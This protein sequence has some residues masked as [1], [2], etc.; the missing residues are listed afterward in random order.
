MPGN[1]LSKNAAALVAAATLMTGLAACGDDGP[2]DDAKAEQTAPNGDVF[3]EVDVSFATEMI[4]H[5]AQA[6]AMVDLTRGREL[7]P[8][9]QKLTENIQAAQ[10]PEIEQMVDWL[11]AWDKPVPETMRDHANAEGHG[12]RG[13]MTDEEM[14]ELETA[15]GEEFETTWLEMMVEHHEGAIEMAEAEQA[16]GVYKPAKKLAESIESSQQ[17]EVDR[18]KELLDS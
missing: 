8:E 2:S 11:A 15:K 1:R 5:H 17:A 16:D 18:M 9:V 7:S 14:S 6:L 13:M 4:P 12:E 3:N 10:G